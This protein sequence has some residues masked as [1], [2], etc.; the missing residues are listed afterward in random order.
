MIIL[1]RSIALIFFVASLACYG[2]RLEIDSLK[3]IIDQKEL[4]SDSFRSDSAY[5]NTL[6]QLAHQYITL[7]IDSTYTLANRALKL[8]NAIQFDG[9]I[10][11]S[12]LH[13]GIYFSEKGKS[14][15]ALE[16]YCE[17]LEQAEKIKDYTLI[18]DINNNIGI[19]YHL[20]GEYDK[21]LEVHLEN[22]A[23][24]NLKAKRKIT[25]ANTNIAFLFDIQGEHLVALPY[26]E[27]AML[28]AKQTKDSYALGLAMSNLSHEYTQCK[29]YEKARKQIEDAKLF[30]EEH[31]YDFLL[32]E[33]FLYE[34]RLLYQTGDIEGA[35]KAVQTSIDFLNETNNSQINFAVRY[36]LMANILLKLGDYSKALKFGE[37]AYTIAKV[38][39]DLRGLVRA[40]E[41]LYMYHKSM[42]APEKTL[43]FL[44]EF[45]KY[46]DSLFNNQ[47][48]NGILLLKAKSDFEKRQTELKAQNDKILLAK[49]NKIN[50]SL[51]I[52]LILLCT[53]IPLYL[54]HRKLGLLN[55]RILEKSKLLESREKELVTSNNT[56]D[57]LFSIIGH[58]LKA[59]IDSLRLLFTMHQKKEVSD[60]EFLHFSPKLNKDISSVSFTLTNLLNWGKTQMQGED[61]EKTNF[62]IQ[63]LAN[64][65][66]VLLAAAG[67]AKE[68]TLINEIGREAMAFADPIQIA[69]V[70]RN[71]ISNAIKFTPSKGMVKLISKELDGK[72]QVSIV[73]NGV[74]MDTVTCK[75]ILD[76]NEAYTTYGTD[77][78]KGTGL[79]LLLCYELIR[80]N[81]G[82]IWV[83]SKLGKGTTFHVVLKKI[84]RVKKVLKAV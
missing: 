23:L 71:I 65:V 61:I 59:P 37:K 19:E 82:E 27:Q 56:K 69:I 55:Y 39:N 6:N 29:M 9:G 68:L 20:R 48:K 60:K 67:E 41:T 10:A 36:Q 18:F 15:K 2:Q 62:L 54:K 49:Q 51:L 80:K 11:N 79:G 13:L 57:R 50:T 38:S 8:S 24:A 35:L 12:R 46:S 21:A 30:A 28:S 17:A 16:H 7:Q 4:L 1:K 32:G 76:P 58:D 5:I 14:S 22:L 3:R 84:Q 31:E 42:G 73:D 40:S 83:E 74:G 52:I 77:N 26:Y 81:D 25:T 64:E 78:E 75:K 66:L 63:P 44:E 72:L 47:N 53:L 34:G 33:Q 45:K 43:F 70:L